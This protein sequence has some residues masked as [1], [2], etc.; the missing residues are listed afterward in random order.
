MPLLDKT[1][2]LHSQHPK[3]YELIR[4]NRMLL[5][6]SFPTQLSKSLLSQLSP[7]DKQLHRTALL[8]E[9]STRLTLSFSCYAFAFLGIALGI[10]IHRKESSIG[11]ALTL[12]MVFFFYFFIIVADSLVGHP[13]L[14]P[15]LIVWFPFV[16]AESLGFY[17]IYRSR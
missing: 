13:E 4:L 5:E 14:H 1:K 7:D 10:K 2:K 16:I 12:V 6:D 17:L 8:V 11:I 3:G 9:A 15:H